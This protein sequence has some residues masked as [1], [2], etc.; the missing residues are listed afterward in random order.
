VAVIVAA[1]VAALFAPSSQCRFSP[2]QFF[3]FEV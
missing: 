1:Q 3:D 2:G